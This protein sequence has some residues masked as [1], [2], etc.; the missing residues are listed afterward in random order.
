MLLWS[1]PK[2]NLFHVSAGTKKDSMDTAGTE[3][4]WEIL[5]W[6]RFGIAHPGS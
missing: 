5:D 4:C 6:V 2:Q 1:R 3:E